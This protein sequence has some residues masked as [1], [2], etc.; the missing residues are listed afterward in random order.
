MNVLNVFKGFAKAVTGKTSR[1]V[2]TIAF[3]AKKYAPAAAVVGG[4]IGTVVAGVWAV[5]KTIDGFDEVVDDIN[6]E[7]AEVKEK[8]L[9]PG[10]K[11]KVYVK[12]AWK[13]T[14]FYSGPILLEA[15]SVASILT[16]FK[17]V[18]GRLVAM[19]ATAAALEDANE[20]LRAD[21]AGYREA[22]K[23]KF[24]ENFDEGLKWEVPGC[25]VNGESPVDENGEK[26]SWELQDTTYR[27]GGLSPYA[28]IF[29]EMASEWSNDPEYNKMTLHRIQQ[30]CNDQLNA[31]GYLF[32][33]DVYKEL[34]IP[35]TR[36]GQMVGWL[37]DGNGD[38]YVDFGM[39]DV[40]AVNNRAEFINGYEPS[41]I[42]D[43]N[44][45]G[46]IWDK[47]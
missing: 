34:G 21:H 6:T 18:D 35:C 37:K 17:V 12:G 28:V 5:K 43:F 39:Y 33:N 15:T 3:K 29:D 45:D 46:V 27:E 31:N 4:S 9:G 47:I 40:K 16:G 19:T 32:L 38:G 7:M 41:I 1:K 36:V 42:L 26:G 14:K 11:A 2:A 10:A 8:D 30:I 44:V 23:E 24:G 20:R 22:L 13:I 25:T